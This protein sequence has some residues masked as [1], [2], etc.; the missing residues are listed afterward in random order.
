MILLQLSPFFYFIGINS[1]YFFIKVVLEGTVLS[2]KSFIGIDQ[3][4]VYNFGQTHSQ[5]LC[6]VNEYTPASR[7]CLTHSSVCDSGMDHSNGIDEDSEACGKSTPA[8]VVY[9]LFFMTVGF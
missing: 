3:L 9:L 1:S 2:Q 5:K 7:Q 6:S 8:G 4:L